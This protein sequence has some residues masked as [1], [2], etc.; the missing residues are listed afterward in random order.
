MRSYFAIIFAVLISPFNALATEHRYQEQSWGLGIVARDVNSS[1][2]S[3][4]NPD[5]SFVPLMY[6][7]GEHFFMD[8]LDMGGHL[9]KAEDNQINFIARMSFFDAPEEYQADIQGYHIDLGLQWQTELSSNTAID[10]EVLSDLDTRF[11]GNITG[12]W[13]YEFGDWQLMPAVSLRY[14]SADYNSQY[15]SL[16]DETNERI[17]AGAEFSTNLEAR[18][19]VNSNFYLIGAIGATALDS[20]AYESQVID[21][22]W[23]SEMY[24]GFGFFNAKNKPKKD[25]LTT[26]GYLRVSQGWATPSDIGDI[27][28]GDI[29]QDAHGVKDEYNNQFSSIFYGLPISDDFFGYPIEIYLTPGFIW[30]WDS[31]VQTTE[32]EY[33]LAFKAYTTFDWP[34]T[35]RLG[36]AEGLS[37]IT[38][39]TYIEEKEMDWKGYEGSNLLNYID[40]SLDINLGDLFNT[41]SL[42]DV[43]LGYGLHHRSAVFGGAEQFRRVEGG[44]NYNTVYL[45]FDF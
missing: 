1:F 2:Q 40:I 26:K 41:R 23:N 21:Q 8:G 28:V 45:Q 9:F 25:R 19:H 24:L 14:K 13:H 22:R 35:W 27:I 6:Y 31:P 4:S 34:V 32:Q 15:Y 38:N 30:H 3:P 44:S 42:D 17:G 16:E 20:N 5:P 18:Y 12:Q 37:Y 10:V 7:Q 39:I 43:W 29:D 33:V 36:L 11:Y